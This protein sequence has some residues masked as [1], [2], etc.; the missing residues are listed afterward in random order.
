MDETVIVRSE[1]AGSVLR[2]VMRR[3]QWFRRKCS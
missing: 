2:R 3:A 1:A